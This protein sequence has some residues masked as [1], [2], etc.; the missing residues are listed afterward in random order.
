MLEPV[1]DEQAIS[2]LAEA[3]ISRAAEAE[4]A[5]LAERDLFDVLARAYF[6]DR[7]RALA[8]VAAPFTTLMLESARAV[9]DC[10]IDDALR[11]GVPLPRDPGR[12][13]RGDG[14]VHRAV[15]EVLTDTG[16]LPWQR[17]TRIADAVTG[18]T[19]WLDLAA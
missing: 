19:S 10:L 12:W 8:G 9:W 18:G 2:V 7:S 15:L 16:H 3:L 11:R 13:L 5:L 14:R 1:V 6:R 4:P 17:A